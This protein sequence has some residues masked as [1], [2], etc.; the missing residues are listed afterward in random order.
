M[1][2]CYA[3]QDFKQS[4]MQDQVFSYKWGAFEFDLPQTSNDCFFSLFQQND[5]FM[6]IGDNDGDV[7]EY[8][9]PEMEIILCKLIRYPPKTGKNT[10]DKVKSECAY[11][12]GKSSD[13]YNSLHLRINKMSAGK[14]LVLYNAKFSEHHLTRKL[15]TIVYT[16]FELKLKR[17][18]A[19]KLGKFF[20]EDLER[21]NF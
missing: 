3:K 18:S 7:N 20:V 6:D 16:P 1:T 15:N 9:Y 14:Y 21:R 19:R 11:I 2:V 4:F 5:R 13:L 8:D 10:S 17:I 12:E